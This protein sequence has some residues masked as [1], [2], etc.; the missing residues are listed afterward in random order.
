MEHWLQHSQQ[1]AWS[2]PYSANFRLRGDQDVGQQHARVMSAI[3]VNMPCHH[4]PWCS[5]CSD[6]VCRHD[7][8]N[9]MLPCVVL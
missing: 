1:E 6:P 4:W 3:T 5:T 2:S 9:A 8:L 7:V